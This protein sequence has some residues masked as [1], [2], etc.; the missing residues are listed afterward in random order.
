MAIDKIHDVIY[1]K[2]QEKLI[3]LQTGMIHAPVSNSF[4]LEHSP[5][6]KIAML[7]DA[8]CPDS[9]ATF[10]G[11]LEDK[12]LQEKYNVPL[13]ENLTHQQL[14]D[15]FEEITQ[16]TGPGSERLF[17]EY[18]LYMDLSTTDYR[19]IYELTYHRNLSIEPHISQNRIHTLFVSKVRDRLLLTI[20]E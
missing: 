19:D 15:A 14:L 13:P 8:C 1:D 6:E 4:L 11:V 12:Q 9:I 2:N 5:L 10:L 16:K 7:L 17:E 20:S 3:P 18:R